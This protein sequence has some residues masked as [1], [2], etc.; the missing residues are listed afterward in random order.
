MKETKEGNEYRETNTHFLHF[1]VFVSL[2]SLLFLL[3]RGSCG[4]PSK[5]FEWEGL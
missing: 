5:D 1:P 3:C 4:L 2:Y